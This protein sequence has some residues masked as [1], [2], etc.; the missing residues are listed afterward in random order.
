MGTADGDAQRLHQSLS[1]QRLR[2]SDQRG[3]DEEEEDCTTI[4]RYDEKPVPLGE[5]KN[6]FL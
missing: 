2:R 3:L 4:A 5:C 6:R 1:W